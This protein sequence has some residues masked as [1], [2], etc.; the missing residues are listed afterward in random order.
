VNTVSIQP[1]REGIEHKAEN[2]H[3]HN[4]SL[5]YKNRYLPHCLLSPISMITAHKTLKSPRNLFPF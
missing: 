4:H 1:G 5:P 3:T 2:K